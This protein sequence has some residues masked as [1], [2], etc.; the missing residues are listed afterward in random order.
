VSRLT[1][2]GKMGGSRSFPAL[3]DIRPN[4]RNRCL[5]AVVAL[6]LAVNISATLVLGISKGQNLY[7][8]GAIADHLIQD[9]TFALKDSEPTAAMAPAYPY[10]L[11]FV[12]SVLGT[13]AG[14]A[15]IRVLQALVIS[16]AIIPLYRL[17]REIFPSPSAEVAV[18]LYALYP[19]FVYSVYSIHQLSFTLGVFIL[20]A[21]LGM[22][23]LA[24]PVFQKAAA[25]S[26]LLAVGLLIEPAIMA[27]GLALVFCL[28]F[29]GLRQKN[30][31]FLKSAGIIV[32]GAAIFIS[33][34][35]ARNSEVFGEF[36]FIKRS[37]L[38][39]WRGNNPEFTETGV[40]LPYSEDLVKAK[41]LITEAEIERYLGKDALRYMKSHP[42]ETAKNF[43]V[44]LY[45]LWWFPKILPEESPLLR[46]LIYAPVLAFFLLGIVLA[47]RKKLPVSW[48][49]LG[50]VL[51][52]AIYAGT[53]VLPR[54][55]IP[56]QPFILSFAAY[57][58]VTIVRF[59]SSG[60]GRKLSGSPPG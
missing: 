27:L 49:G 8:N 36:I 17:T 14:L 58:L 10:F 44:K 51:Y 54:Y 21:L 24:Q 16:L 29:R 3:T 19:D 22:R 11:A 31:A 26:I 53:F 15:A 18:L 37:G 60:G 35:L 40:P 46:K 45:H 6:S 56:I 30:A 1:I 5:L 59:L 2:E 28:F 9:H 47:R 7:E 23:L 12:F 42:L 32:L 25:L 55:R 20:V 57:S 38:S 50:L 4:S 34:W 43:L 52:S 48:I 41:G 33:P 13:S 39:L